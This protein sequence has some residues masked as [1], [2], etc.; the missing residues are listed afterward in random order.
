MKRSRHIIDFCST[1]IC[2]L[3]GKSKP[4]IARYRSICCC[5]N[6]THPINPKSNSFYKRC[7]AISCNKKIPKAYFSSPQGEVFCWR[8]DTVLCY[9]RP[10]RRR[11]YRQ[12]YACTYA[13]TAGETDGRFFCSVR[14]DRC[15]SHTAVITAPKRAK[16]TAS[17]G[18][19]PP[20]SCRS[21][22]LL[23]TLSSGDG[24]GG[25]QA[26]LSSP[27]LHC[28]QNLRFAQTAGT[29]FVTSCALLD[30]DSHHKI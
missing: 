16:K 5:Q 27:F 11:A 23:Q 8:R 28:F 26:R 7:K 20:L 14:S 10:G 2:M 3:V 13:N 1:Y 4:S 6:R 12:H 25:V 15:K 24:G 19:I 21:L 9:Q 18:C 22:P 30:I 17:P 29:K